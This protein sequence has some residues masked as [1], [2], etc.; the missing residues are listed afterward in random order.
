MRD[1]IKTSLRTGVAVLTVTGLT[2]T[3]IAVAQTGEDT[4]PADPGTDESSEQFGPR[5]RFGRGHHRGGNPVGT[6]AELTGL[7]AQEVI[8]QVSEA[9][10]SIADVAAANGSSGD[11]VIAAMLANLSERLEEKVADERLTQEEADE[12][13]A[14]AEE[15][16]TEVVNDPDAELRRGGRGPGRGI[17]A[18]AVAEVL[19]VTTDELRQAKQDGVSLA[20]LAEQQGVPIDDV[21]DVLVAPLAERLD[22]K[23]AAGDIT[24]EEAD[25]KL[26]EVEERIE[27]G[28][29]PG[30]RGPGRGFDRGP[31][32]FGP[33]GPAAEEATSA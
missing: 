9:G 11:E 21:V 23:V 7:T 13:L 8:D 32:G 15:R 20:D 6:V 19:G 16:I 27:S 3:G 33:G 25:E 26:A 31:G 22:E 14:G 18:E 4:E 17:D 24:Q 1:S 30:R 2:M 12:K 28:E 5:G 10:T 29:A